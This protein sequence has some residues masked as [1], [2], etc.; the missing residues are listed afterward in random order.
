MADQNARHNQELGENPPSFGSSPPPDGTPPSFGNPPPSD[1]PPSDGPPP[2]GPP[3]DGPP[4]LE[5]PQPSFDKSERS[6]PEHNKQERSKRQADLLANLLTLLITGIIIAGG[7]LLPTLL[8]PY[9]DLYR[10]ETIQLA[11]PPENAISEHVFEEPVVLYPWNI[12]KEEALRTLSSTERNFLEDRGIPMFLVAI[13]RD[14]G[15]RM[16]YDEGSYHAQIINA[17]RYL[18]PENDAEPGC[19]ILADM[20]IDADGQADLR[21]AVDPNGNIISLLFVSSSWD[22]LRISAPIGVSLAQTTEE[23]Q[24]NGEGDTTG[25]N[26]DTDTDTST[27]TD[28]QEGGP[29]GQGGETEANTPPEAPPDVAS[30]DA[31]S[32]TTTDTETQPTDEA[33][34]NTTP[35]IIE[36]LPVEEDRYLWSFVYVFS[37]EAKAIDQQKLFGAFRQLEVTYEYR[38]GYPFTILLPVQAAEPELL[39]EVEYMAPTPTVFATEEYL[40]Y[41]YDMPDGERLILYLNPISLRCMGFNLLSY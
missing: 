25:A 3:P 7:F 18:E 15:L 19:F 10:G 39:P 28:V 16:D 33:T 17:F 23:G 29:E 32:D 30:P 2:D 4:P 24:S 34:T 5:N 27:G 35:P 6:K 21:C 8:Y 37:R 14:Y 40:L 9:L 20:D 36:H 26:A 38:Y 13:L 31:E 11:A 12:Y 41:I 22:T 1:G